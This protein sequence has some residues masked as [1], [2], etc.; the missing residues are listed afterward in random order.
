MSIRLTRSIRPAG[1]AIGLLTVAFALA[2]ASAGA[3]FG[4]LGEDLRLSFMGPDG[5]VSF[6]AKSPSVAHNPTANEYLVVW[7]GNDNIAP[8][9][10]DEVE[11]FGQ[12][13]SASGAP[14]GARIRVSQQGAASPR[15]QRPKIRASPTTG[16]RTSTWSHGGA[17]SARARS[18][19]S[20]PSGCPLPA[21]R[22]ASTI[23]GS[24]TWAR[25]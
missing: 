17:R 22:S 20:S 23:S 10:D 19:R 6:S 18:S 16:P 24:P 25:S 4:P 21:P 2:P 5:S 7:H 8:L 3:A 13:L 9:L 12:R 14:L 15:S 11:I 1:L